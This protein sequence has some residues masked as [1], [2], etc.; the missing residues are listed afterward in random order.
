VTVNWKRLTVSRRT[1]ALGTFKGSSK[2]YPTLFKPNPTPPTPSQRSGLYIDLSRISTE[3]SQ[4]NVARFYA[5]RILSQSQL[6]SD[7]APKLDAAGQPA[8]QTFFELA[9]NWHD[10]VE[11]L[12]QTTL[13]LTQSA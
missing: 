5:A 1:A 10:S 8:W 12:L 7:I 4:R 2:S 9:L 13:S 6:D 11:D 3:N